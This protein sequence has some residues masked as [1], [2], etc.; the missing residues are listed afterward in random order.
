MYVKEDKKIFLDLYKHEDVQNEYII[1][2]TD[3]RN[4]LLSTLRDHLKPQIEGLVEFME[5]DF[6]YVK[7]PG[8]L[9]LFNHKFS[10]IIKYPSLDKEI[11]IGKFYA[12][13]WVKNANIQMTNQEL[14]EFYQKVVALV[15]TNMDPSFLNESKEGVDEAISNLL[16]C[17]KMIIKLND[18]FN[19][20]KIINTELIDQIISLEEKD[21]NA[22]ILWELINSL[23]EMIRKA[24][25]WDEIFK[26]QYSHLMTQLEVIFTTLNERILEFG[27]SL[28]QAETLS[29]LINIINILINTHPEWLTEGG[30]KFKL[31]TLI[32]HTYK[33]ITDLVNELSNLRFEDMEKPQK[34]KYDDSLVRD[35]TVVRKQSMRSKNRLTQIVNS[36]KR[37]TLISN[38]KEVRS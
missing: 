37:N 8:N 2:N 30:D 6:D 15:E 22:F 31:V 16:L 12:R 13:M 4:H 18:A 20:K 11:K 9:P 21:P 28:I 23:L 14:D 5:K 33:N 7:I 36:F 25:K 38:V 17:T 3:T 32:S 26:P 10:R 29:E 34:I 1:W 35:K 19:Y 24:L 27:F